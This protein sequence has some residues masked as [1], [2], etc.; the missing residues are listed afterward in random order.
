MQLSVAHAA[1]RDAAARL[2]ALQAS[3]GL[4]DSGAGQARIDI[5][6]ALDVVLVSIPIADGV[7]TIDTD[8]FQIILT[9]PIEAQIA[10]A[11]TADHA[12]IY[13]N[14]SEVWADDVTVS[15]EAG[16]G[17]VKLATTTLQAGAFC[18]LT[19]AVLQG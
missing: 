6:D 2:P 17:E 4:L 7:G 8:L 9:V 3:F 15:D 11:G 12:V 19:S 5:L 18:R 14:T 16:S 13:D 10:T 1:A